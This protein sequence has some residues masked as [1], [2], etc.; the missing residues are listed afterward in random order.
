MVRPTHW[1]GDDCYEKD[2]YSQ[3][4]RG[5]GD[6]HTMEGHTEEYQVQSGGRRS[7]WKVW[8]RAFI[9]VFVGKVRQ[10]KISRLRIGYFEFSGL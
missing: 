9:M 4:P 5:R 3:F 8:A 7:K 1:S 10:D 6:Y 2:S